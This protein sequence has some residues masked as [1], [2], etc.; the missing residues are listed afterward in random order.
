MTVEHTPLPVH[1]YTTQGGD[2]VGIVNAN[3]EHEEVILR[4]LDALAL[5]GEIDGRWLAVGRTHIE[6]AF[7]AINRAVFKPQRLTDLVII[8]DDGK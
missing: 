6:Q 5:N 4:R 8:G 2:K 3:K 1:G 7:M